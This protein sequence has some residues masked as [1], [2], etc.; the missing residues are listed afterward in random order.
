MVKVIFFRNLMNNIDRINDE[1]YKTI[2]DTLQLNQNRNPEVLSL[3]YQIS[4]RKG[5]T[6]LFNSISNFLGS[7]GR[8]KY[9]KYVYHD[10]FNVNKSFAT[11]VYNENKQK[12]HKVLNQIIES[13]FDKLDVN[14]RNL[15]T[16]TKENI[17]HIENNNH[18]KDEF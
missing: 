15:L 13:M 16:D 10:L 18:Q 5:R 6:E 12:Y 4:L 8:I 11:R 2:S 14:W 3:W 9:V 7:H 17:G 1:I